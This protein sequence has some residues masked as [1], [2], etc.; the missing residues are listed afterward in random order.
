MKGCHPLRRPARG[1][2][3]SPVHPDAVRLYVIENRVDTMAMVCPQC[4]ASHEQSLHCPSCGVRLLYQS[5]QRRPEGSSSG[6]T[7]QWLHT[8]VGRVIAGILLAQG[9][10]YGLQLLCTAGALAAADD[11]EQ[12][13]WSTLYGL[14]LLQVLQGMSLLIGGGLAGAGQR[15]APLLG[16]VVGL[17]HGVLFLSIQRLQGTPQTE[18]SLY[19]QPILHVV[20]GVVGAIIGTCIW[21]PLPT[22]AMPE[23]ETDK[24]FQPL[25]SRKS[26]F[27][28]LS[29][30]IAW[31][32]V[33]AGIV[34]VT[35]GFLWGPGMLSVM[36]D[37]SQGK[38]RV[39]DHLQAQL[40]TWEIIGLATLFGGAMA[41]ATTRN[42]LKQGLFVGLGASIVLVGNYLGGKA[43]LLEQSL[44]MVGSIVCLTLVGGWFGGQLF[45]PVQG[46]PRFRSMGAASH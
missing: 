38:L 4:K 13:V 28:L 34:F 20:F 19:G 46:I 6:S 37:A 25:R 30:P 9:L 42:G 10:A 36:L 31:G 5:H 26:R 2:Q 40:V 41:G 35:A 22:L 29:G 7:G 16:L 45:P 21:R 44:Y 14:V 12:S 39:T 8:A 43:F 24:D 27:A 11:V 23:F 32:R 18:I 17:V 33:F 15:R 3:P 1:W